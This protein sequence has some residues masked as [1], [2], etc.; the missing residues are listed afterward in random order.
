M[1][2]LFPSPE[3]SVPA[4]IAALEMN[5]RC[6]VIWMRC[7]HGTAEKQLYGKMLVNIPYMEHMSKLKHKMEWKIERFGEEGFVFTS[8]NIFVEIQWHCVVTFGYVDPKK[9]VSIWESSFLIM[10]VSYARIE[11]I[12]LECLGMVP[13]LILSPYCCLNSIRSLGNA[14]VQT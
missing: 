14:N 7:T 12:S 3:Q 8:V 6:Q 9:V 10:L 13:H 2:N 5:R 4:V 11:E 1:G